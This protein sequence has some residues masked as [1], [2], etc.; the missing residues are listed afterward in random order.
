MSKKKFK[1]ITNKCITLQ[2]DQ[3]ALRRSSHNPAAYKGRVP[4]YN[5]ERPC[6]AYLRK[7]K[8]A[9]FHQEQDKRVRVGLVV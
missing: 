3:V 2:H 1:I 7:N 4:K 5:F 8:S 9:F 6:C